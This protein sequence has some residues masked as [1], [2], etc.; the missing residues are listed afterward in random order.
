MP[1][2]SSTNKH[3]TGMTESRETEGERERERWRGERSFSFQ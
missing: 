3:E 2:K 1:E